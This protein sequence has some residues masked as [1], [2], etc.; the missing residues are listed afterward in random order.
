M[1][2]GLPEAQMRALF[3][4]YVEA[5]RN[6]AERTDNLKLESLAK[7]V[8]EMLPK[9]REKHPGKKVGFAIVVKDFESCAFQIPFQPVRHLSNL[10]LA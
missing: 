3:D 10:R 7:S 2:G 4:R 9:L 1:E 8:T 6:N 5:R